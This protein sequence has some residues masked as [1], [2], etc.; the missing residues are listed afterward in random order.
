MV[1]EIDLEKCTSCGDCES[2]CLFGAIEVINDKAQW[3]GADAPTYP[4]KLRTGPSTGSAT[5]LNVKN[6]G[7]EYENQHGARVYDV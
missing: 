1:I 2:A 3:I 4:C 7:R 6:M 5:V